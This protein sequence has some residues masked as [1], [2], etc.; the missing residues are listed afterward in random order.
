MNIISTTPLETRD[1]CG[2][3]PAIMEAV[4]HALGG[5]IDLDPCSNAEAQ[6]VVRAKTHW[7]IDDDCTQQDWVAHGGPNASLWV[8]PPYSAPAM[9]AIVPHI[10]ANA[11]LFGRGAVVLVNAVSDTAYGADLMDHADAVIFPRRI[12]FV[13][14]AKGNPHR[15]MFCVWGCDAADA[16]AQE[17]DAVGMLRSVFLKQDAIRDWSLRMAAISADDQADDRARAW[18]GCRPTCMELDDYEFFCME[19]AA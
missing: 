16:L 4:R 2:T 6:K 8:N 10:I 19:A 18:L 3:P 13:G 14:Q 15:Q 7:T 9:R 1:S 11:P 5:T 12:N 17:L